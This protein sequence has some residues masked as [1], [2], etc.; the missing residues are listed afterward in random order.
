MIALDHL[1]DVLPHAELERLA[2]VFDVNAVNQV[3]LPGEAVFVCLLNG[4]M[5]G[6]LLTQ[7]M[8]KANYEA[9]FGHSVHSSSFGHRL[10]VIKPAYFEAIFRAV[11]RRVKP[12]MS[13][14]DERALR[15]RIVDATEVV[16]S[17]KLIN[18][19]IHFGSGGQAGKGHNRRHVKSVLTL[20]GEGWPDFLRLCRAQ[21]EASDNVALGDAIV[22]ATQPGDLWIV[23]GGVTD[24]DRLLAIHEKGGFF[25]VPHQQQKWR[26]LQTVWEARPDATAA[27]REALLLAAKQ[28]ERR[29]GKRPPAPYRLLRV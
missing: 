9:L 15:L 24:R 19:G 4:V 1:L 11:Y 12:M 16:L 25:I 26:V 7:G 5:N 29:T 20:S 17:A 27:E 28:E 13:P 6:P 21:T 18:F 8:L 14:S 3:R 22:A 23:D 10:E 2:T